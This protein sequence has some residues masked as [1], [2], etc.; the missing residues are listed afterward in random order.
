MSDPAA[1]SE[2]AG[3]EPVRRP[4]FQPARLARRALRALLRRVLVRWSV[5]AVF[6]EAG[7]EAAD[8]LIYLL[9]RHSLVD[10][11][12]LDAVLRQRRLPA[13]R[14]PPARPARTSLGNG[15][16]ISLQDDGRRARLPAEL[17]A[18]AREA[19]SDGAPPARIVPVNVFWGRAPERE[20]SNGRRL[21]WL[22]IWAAEGWG[23]RSRLRKALAVLFFRRDVVVKFAPPLDLA[24]L[25][26]IA[27]AEGLDTERF[28]LRLARL[29]RAAL[30][31]DREAVVGPDLSHRRTLVEAILRDP[32]VREAIAAEAAA[33]NQPVT[34]VERRAECSALAIAA[35]YS[36]PIVRLLDRLLTALWQRIYDG[37][38]IAG[39]E[40][41]PL[42]A[43]D[44]TLVY[45]PCHRSHIDYLLLSYVLH[46]A[47]LNIPHIA[48]GENLNLPVVGRILRGG[49][50]FFLRRSFKD[51]AL[52]GEVFA[53][54]LHEVLR[55]GFSVEYFVE[56][57]RSRTGRMLPPKAGLISMTVQSYLR[58]HDRP[59]A[60]MPIYV[61]YERLIE[62]GSYGEELEG[63][64]K[65]RESVVGLFRAVLALRGQRY[66]RVG[67]QFAR[68]IFLQDI[69]EEAGATTMEAWLASKALRRNTLTVLSRRIAARINA[70]V[71][72]NPVA[73]TAAA[74]LATPRH[75][76]DLDQLAHYCERLLLL[77]PRTQTA[78]Q[79]RAASLNGAG[80]I[81]HASA[82]GYLERRSHVFGEVVTVPAAQVPFLTYFR[83]NVQH[84]FAVPSL[85]ACLVIQHG[86]LGR[87]K[88][89][90]LAKPLYRV[91]AAECY[92]DDWSDEA[93]ASDD[94]RASG[95][96]VPFDSTL[97]AMLDQGWLVAAEDV[98]VISVPRPEQ[99]EA[100][101]LEW[102]AAAVRPTLI[103]HAL[104]LGVIDRDRRDRLDRGEVEALAQAA[105]RHLAMTHLFAA[106][107]FSDRSQ[108]R[109]ALDAFA[110]VGLVRIDAEGVVVRGEGLDRQ[111]AA[112]AFLLPPDVRIAMARTADRQQTHMRAPN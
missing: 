112:A 69:L 76:A 38:E 17:A 6:P 59:L 39:I 81:E 52:Y 30:R 80:V 99:L 85:I 28:A 55:R 71:M 2:N 51:D 25:A 94:P 31:E 109:L 19:L 16:L 73:L 75:A 57:G 47:G 46:K 91:L 111:A 24:A 7:P 70:A 77:L 35:D 41:L 79:L 8:R 74:I 42:L 3:L 26:P 84:L 54:Y 96:F 106:P 86:S 5:V 100:Q 27:L 45:V 62:G 50:A 43:R 37:V 13:V 36:Y 83:N 66:G 64:A 63:G 68:P 107:E 102:L 82:M 20:A 9:A 104:L 97:A 12:L 56:G 72:L 87:A 88:L 78:P 32:R 10:A 34:R 108:F 93:E 101:H 65:K 95:P 49:G 23:G 67:L 92:L 40:Q 21:R 103:R 53:A 89:A 90:R 48:A 105:A 14:D 60:F 1:A 11:A 110:H 61:G 18:L 44:H 58:A 4:L 29:G 22:R 98:Q 15:S 33:R